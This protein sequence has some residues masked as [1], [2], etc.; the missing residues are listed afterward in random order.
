[1]ESI[2]RLRRY[3]ECHDKITGLTATCIN[4]LIDS[5]KEEVEG[6]RDFCERLDD[7]A[8]KR[9]DVTLW[10]VEY[11]ALPV[12]AGGEF[13]HVGD[14]MES[15]V[16]HLFDEASFKVCAIW[17]DEGG[18]EVVDSLG[19]HYNP[20]VLCHHHHAPT[21]EDVLLEACKAYH[22]L[23]VEGMSDFA[24]DMPAPSEV[25]AEFAAKLRL[26]GED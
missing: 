4:H 14:V 18:W 10:G 12:D 20:D 24:H 1:M 13:I 11:M 15:D 8:T 5:I 9:E 26:A 23:I 7:A 25:I 19:D 21:V 16:D 2:D 17:L 22:G 3:V 6:M